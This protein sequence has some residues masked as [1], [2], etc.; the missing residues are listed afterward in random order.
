MDPCAISTV[1]E[2]MSTATQD[3]GHLDK[4]F[5][6][7]ESER[8]TKKKPEKTESI[9]YMYEGYQIRIHFTGDNTFR[10]CIQNLVERKMG[11]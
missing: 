5:K 11:G 1:Q 10:Q 8:D 2:V 6:R 9:R 7:M 3:T 4:E